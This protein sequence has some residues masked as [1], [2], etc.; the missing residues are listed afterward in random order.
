MTN[1]I[2]PGSPRAGTSAAF[3]SPASLPRRLS[4]AEALV[5]GLAEELRR[6]SRVFTYGQDV[7]DFG[8]IMQ[9]CQGLIEEFG[10]ERVRGAPISEAAIVGTG[11]GAAL[12]GQ[13]PVVEISFGE[14]LPCAMNQLALQAPNLR[15]M[16]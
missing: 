9:S 11:L 5:E 12:F 1:Q 8:G 13:R 14:F 16:T 4:F 6:D 7:G 2:N 3:T 15:Y 10:P